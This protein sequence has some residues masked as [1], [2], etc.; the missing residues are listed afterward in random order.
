MLYKCILL[1]LQAAVVSEQ[2]KAHQKAV[3]GQLLPKV[4]AVE[5][6]EYYLNAKFSLTKNTVPHEMKF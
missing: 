2:R 3:D 6:L 4:K 5:N 1:V